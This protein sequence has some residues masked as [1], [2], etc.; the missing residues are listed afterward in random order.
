MTLRG[1]KPRIDSR[2]GGGSAVDFATDV[3]YYL[4]LS[5]RQLPSRYLYDALGSTLFEAI[6][7]LPGSY[8]VPTDARAAVMRAT[9][10]QGVELVFQK[11]YDI[12]T[13]KTKYRLDTL[14]GVAM[15]NPEMA[16]VE[17]FNQP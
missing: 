15:L 11:F 7:L 12:N 2:V 13:M 6:C 17:L 3:A 8:A 5:P 9:T 4:T 14:F 16:G 10:E 1:S